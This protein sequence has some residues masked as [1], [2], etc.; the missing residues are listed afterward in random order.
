MAAE[1]HEWR[2]FSALRRPLLRGYRRLLR[3]R[4]SER[5]QTLRRFLLRRSERIDRGWVTLPLARRVRLRLDL[6]RGN[7][8]RIFWAHEGYE[9]ALQWAL[10][11]LLPE[12][13]SVVDCGANAGLMGFLALARAAARVV[14]VEP[15]P[16]LAAQLRRNVALNGLGGRASVVECAASRSAGDAVLHPSTADQDGS[17]ALEPNKYSDPQ[18]ALLPV[19]LR[20]LDRILEEQQLAHVDLLKVDAEYHD[21]EVLEGLGD[22][23]RPERVEML[24]V[25][26]T[27]DQFAPVFAMLSAAG[28]VPF[29]TSKPK[30]ELLAQALSAQGAGL[31]FHPYR[32]D[33]RRRDVFWCSRGGRAH[34]RL[35]ERL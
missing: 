21:R 18:A 6:S 10:R 16:R 8:R 2:G 17:H 23:L 20:R 15:H 28:Y 27:G 7:Q 12:D 4:A 19:R 33:S 26:M 3:S 13:S 5:S 25:E 35:L 14:F 30:K 34:R 32:E 22:W 29:G 24:Y 9:P 1:L 11:E 31:L